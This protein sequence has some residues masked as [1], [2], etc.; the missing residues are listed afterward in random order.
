MIVVAD[1]EPVAVVVNVRVGAARRTQP[2]ADH[3]RRC[4]HRVGG[5][6]R[7]Q[8]PILKRSKEAQALLALS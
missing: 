8:K 6:R 2:P 3:F 5:S 4:R 7:P 1:A